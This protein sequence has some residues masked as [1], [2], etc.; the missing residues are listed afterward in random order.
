MGSPATAMLLA[1]WVRVE[2]DN[3]RK[4]SYRVRKDGCYDLRRNSNQSHQSVELVKHS[5]TLIEYIESAPV[6]YM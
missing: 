2:W 5:V 1:G 3:G 6:A 4:N